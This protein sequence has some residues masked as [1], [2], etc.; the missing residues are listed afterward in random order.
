MAKENRRGSRDPRKKESRNKIT[1][2][3][4]IVEGET[5]K[6]YFKE[7]FKD[8]NINI[9]S[10]IELS[11]GTRGGGGY[12]DFI[13]NIEKNRNV[14]DVVI[15]IT[16]LD[17][18]TDKTK[19]TEKDNLNSLI[20]L[21]EKENMKNNI[22]LTLDDFETWIK[23]MFKNEP[24]NLSEFLGFGD[25]HKGKTNVYNSVIKKDGSFEIASKKFAN[26]NLYYT[27]KEFKK[28]KIEIDNLFLQQSNL[29]YFLEYIQK[30][31]ETN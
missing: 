17:K 11:R 28:G 25:N 5:E 1:T 6:Q 29:T 8:K 26:E 7:M 18:A 16:D 23:S 10:E 3:K 30:I 27:K 14:N 2:I 20:K 19:P 13:K 12:K 4:F 15:V 22:F 9:N 24:K 31:I 21:L